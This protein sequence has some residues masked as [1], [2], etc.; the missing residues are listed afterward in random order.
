LEA[1]QAEPEESFDRFLMR[2]Y[3]ELLSQPGF[4]FAGDEQA[5]EM[6]ANLVDSAQNFYRSVEGRVEGDGRGLGPEFLA[7]VREGLMSASYL[8]SWQAQPEQAVQLV[9]V[10]AFL[11]A[12]R[13]AAVQFRLNI[14]SPAWYDR[15]E[16]PLGH[17]YV[18]SRHWPAG[19][20]WTDLEEYETAQET[21]YR[22]A[23]GLIRRCRERV[24]LGHSTL[25][26]QGYEQRGMLLRAFER[27]MDRFDELVGPAGG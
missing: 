19:R 16:Q 4:G 5:E 3:A 18:L 26:E 25:S 24:Y 1:Y 12:N 8:R 13:P 20:A 7:T 23:A 21:L 22:L 17:P 27:V 9:P 11:S 2:I 14:G 6:A 10:A 15:P